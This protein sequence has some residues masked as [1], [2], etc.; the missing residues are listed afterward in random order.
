MRISTQAVVFLV[1]LNAAAGVLTASGA[2]ADMGVAPT[3]GGG[4]QVE[5]ANNSAA[6]VS[7]G[8]GVGE[9][10]FALYVTATQTVVDIFGLIFAGPTMLSNLGLPTWLVG[11]V[12]APAY[13]IAGADIIF[14]LIGRGP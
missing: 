11:F 8:S 9:T 4:E 1:F 7:P 3:P 14:V 13:I 10:L 5:Q 2:A 12:F 6:Q